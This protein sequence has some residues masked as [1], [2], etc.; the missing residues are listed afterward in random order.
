MA[1]KEKKKSS[2]WSDFKKFITKGN[3]LDLAVAVVI[4]GAFGKITTGLVNYIITPFTSLFLGKVDMTERWKTVLVEEVKNAAGEV[5]TKEVALQWGAW[6]QTILDFLIIA[7][8]IFIVL[9]ILMKLQNKLHE[10]ELAEAAAEA[11]KKAEQERLEKEAA[12][13][14]EAEK[15]AALQA[16]EDAFY[17]DV[18][19]QAE[20]LS[21]IRDLLKQNKN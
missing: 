14:A 19:R 7:F 6:L 16:R 17:R 10:K 18:T 12:E 2:F 13:A 3:V 11:E 1:K 21:E 5:I 9:R 20:L 4:G 15:K 8:C